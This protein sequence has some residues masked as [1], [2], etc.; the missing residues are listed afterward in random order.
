MNKSLLLNILLFF[1]VVSYGQNLDIPPFGTD[2]TFEMM[3]WNIEWFPKNGQTTV[4]YV[5][6]IIQDLNVDLIAMQEL[7]DTLA[8]EQMMIDLDQYEGYYKSSWFAGCWRIN[9]LSHST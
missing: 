2:S 8:F 4:D 9:Y 1:G 3:T 7:D 6:E 5:S